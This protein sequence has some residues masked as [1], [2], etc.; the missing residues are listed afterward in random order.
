MSERFKVGDEI[1]LKHSK[2]GEV[3]IVEQIMAR[4]MATHYLCSWRDVPWTPIMYS[5]E[6][7]E[8]AL[9]INH[10]AGE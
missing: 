6:Y 9:P 1:R 10:K 3:V 2:N 4:G 7:V 8:K 5:H